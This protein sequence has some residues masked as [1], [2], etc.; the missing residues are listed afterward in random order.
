MTAGLFVAGVVIVALVAA[1]LWLVERAAAEP[2]ARPSG[3]APD[4]KEETEVRE[5]NEP[6]PSILLDAPNE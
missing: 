4:P 5:R 6:R 1:G 2:A 3:R